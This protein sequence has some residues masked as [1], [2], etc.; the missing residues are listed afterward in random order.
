[1]G[2]VDDDDYIRERVDPFFDYDATISDEVIPSTC[3]SGSR[4]LGRKVDALLHKRLKIFR[5]TVQ[6]QAASV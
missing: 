1:M 3:Q 6:R 4:D 5:R 2:H